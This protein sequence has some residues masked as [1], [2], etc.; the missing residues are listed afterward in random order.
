MK[1]KKLESKAI[2]DFLKKNPKVNLEAFN[3]MSLVDLEAL[4]WP[5]GQSAMKMLESLKIFQRLMRLTDDLSTAQ[6]LYDAGFH[7]AAQIASKPKQ[8]FISQYS[9]CFVANDETA[10]AQAALVYQRAANIFR[11]SQLIALNVMPKPYYQST[12]F[13]SAPQDDGDPSNFYKTMPSYQDLFGSLDYCA[14]EDCQSVLSPAAYFVDLMRLINEGGITQPEDDKLKLSNRRSDLWEIPLDC[15]NTNQE[16]PYLDLVNKILIQAATKSMYGAPEITDPDGINN[17]P[18]FILANAVYP[19]N[20]PS[21]LPLD[22]L[23]C[24]LKQNNVSLVEIYRLFKVGDSQLSR[25]MLSLSIEKLELITTED[26]NED[27]LQTYYNV[28][29]LTTLKAV[30]TFMQQTGLT[31][32]QLENLIYQNLSEAELDTIEIPNRLFINQ[33]LTNKFMQIASDPNNGTETLR[34]INHDANYDYLH[35]FIRLAGQLGWQFADLDWALRTTSA[36]IPNSKSVVINP[37]A[38]HYLARLNDFHRRYKTPIDVLCSFFA[39]IKTTG[40]GND[41]VSQALFDRV[42]NQPIVFDDFSDEGNSTP[43]YDT[44]SLKKPYHPNYDAE[45]DDVLANPLYGDVPLTWTYSTGTGDDKQYRAHLLSA[46]QISDADLDFILQHMS[47]NRLITSDNNIL[48]DVPHLTQLYRF[49]QAAQL[50]KMPVVENVLLHDMLNIAMIQSIDD[51]CALEEWVDWLKT[52]P[53][54]TYQLHYLINYPFAQAVSLRPDSFTVS[55]RA[56]NIGL[57]DSKNIFNQLLKSKFITLTGVVINKQ[58]LTLSNMQTLFGAGTS[59][60][61]SDDQCSWIQSVLLRYYQ[62]QYNPLNAANVSIKQLDV[63]YDNDTVLPLVNQLQESASEV[64]IN[65]DN[66]VCND[67]ESDTEISSFQSKEIFALLVKAELIT[68]EGVV[69]HQDDTVFAHLKLVV[70]EMGLKPIVENE[71]ALAWQIIKGNYK[72]AWPVIKKE[73][74]E[75][76]AAIKSEYKK[77]QTAIEDTVEECVAIKN[78]YEADRVFIKSVLDKYLV[79]QTNAVQEKLSNFLDSPVD[80]VNSLRKILPYSIPSALEF[81][82][83]ADCYVGIEGSDLF[84]LSEKNFTIDLWVNVSQFSKTN[85]EIVSQGLNWWLCQN[86]DHNN[87]LHFYLNTTAGTQYATVNYPDDQQW[88]HIAVTF[89]GTQLTLFVDGLKGAPTKI[90]ENL[91][92]GKGKIFLGANQHNFDKNV[93]TTFKGQMARVRIWSTVKAIP[94][95]MYDDTCQADD[96]QACWLL[97]AGYGHIIYNAAGVDYPGIIS[98]GT[99][100][101]HNYYFNHLLEYTEKDDGKSIIMDA[102]L[103][104]AQLAKHNNLAQWLNLDAEVMQALLDCPQSFGLP[105]MS[106]GF[107]YSPAL[108]RSLD[109][110]RVFS[111]TFKD[112]T[113]K[114]LTYFAISSQDEAVEQSNKI[115]SLGFITGWDEADI[116]L[117][118]DALSDDAL[119]AGKGYDFNSMGGIAV[120]QQ[121]FQL[122]KR[123]NNQPQQLID[124]ASLNDKYATEANW[125]FY[126][127]IVTDVLQTSTALATDPNKTETDFIRQESDQENERNLLAGYLLAQL[128][129]IFDDIKT[130][131]DL[132]AFLLV[133][134]K[135][136]G[137]TMISPIKLGINSL[138]LYIQRCQLSLENEATY[139]IPDRQWQWMQ[140]YVIWRANRE[141]YLYPENYID[142][143]LRRIKT[144]PYETLQSA[145]LQGDVTEKTV[146]DAL[147]RYVDE[148]ASI[149]NMKVVDA[150]YC[151]LEKEAVFCN[152]A[153]NSSVALGG[154]TIFLFAKSSLEASTF[155]HRTISL[156]EIK[157]DKKNLKPAHYASPWRK[158]D[159][160]ISSDTLSGIYAFNT[161]YVFWVEQ[162][163]K[164]LTDDSDNQYAITTAAIKFSFQTTDGKWSPPQ[165][166]QKDIVIFASG[167]KDK[168]YK[169]YHDNLKGF[170]YTPNGDYKYQNEWRKVQLMLTQSDNQQNIL[171]EYGSLVYSDGTEEPTLQVSPSD[172]EEVQQFNETMYLAAKNAYDLASSE[173]QTSIIPALMLSQDLAV[174]SYFLNYAPGNLN[175]DKIDYTLIQPGDTP[176]KPGEY[177]ES[178][179]EYLYYNAP[180]QLTGYWSFDDTLYDVNDEY[181]ATPNNNSYSWAKDTQDPLGY[182]YVLSCEG[183]YGWL[184]DTSDSFSL[185]GS[186]NTYMLIDF[187]FNEQSFSDS[188]YLMSKENEWDLMIGKDNSGS[189][190]R[191]LSFKFYYTGTFSTDSDDYIKVHTNNQTITFKDQEWH[192]VSIQVFCTPKGAAQAQVRVLLD[193]DGVSY[194]SKLKNVGQLSA[195]TSQKQNIEFCKSATA[196][197]NVPLYYGYLSGLSIFLCNNQSDKFTIFP[198]YYKG[199]VYNELCQSFPNSGSH[200]VT[201]NNRPNCICYGTGDDTF[202]ITPTIDL[203]GDLSKSRTVSLEGKYLVVAFDIKPKRSKIISIEGE[204]IY[205]KFTRLSTSVVNELQRKLKVGGAK[206]LLTLSSQDAEELP[207]DRYN[208]TSV[209]MT[210]RIDETLNF[211]GAYGCYFWELFF[212]IPFLIANQFNAN[213]K[214][215]LSKQWYEHV[216][217]PSDGD[218]CWRFIPLQN[219]PSDDYDLDNMLDRPALLMI[220]DNDPFDPD[221]LARLQHGSYQKAIVM[222]YIDNL[223]QWGDALFSQYTW[224]TNTEATLLY[225]LADDLLG[226]EP[227][228]VYESSPIEPQTFTQLE[229]DNPNGIPQFLI[230]VEAPLTPPAM[231][232]VAMDE[233]QPFNLFQSYFCISENKRFMQYWKTTDDRLYKLRHGMNIQGQ[234]Q[235][236]ALFQEALDPKQLMSN[237]SSFRDQAGRL[238]GPAPSVPYYRFNVILSLARN[239]AGR[240]AQLGSEL[241]SALEKQSAEQMSL[242][243]VTQEAS[244]L[245]LM[246]QI[247]QDQINQLM[248]TQDSLE[249]SLAN[250]TLRQDTMKHLIEKGY[251]VWEAESLAFSSESLAFL[252]IAEALKTTATP[253]YLLPTEFGLVVGGS[254]PGGSL[255]CAA[256]VFQTAS[257]LCGHAAQI[258]ST[259]GQFQRRKHDWELQRDLATNDIAQMNAQIE[260]NDYAL[261]A[262]QQDLVINQR[263]IVYANKVERFVKTK[264][265]NQ[266]LY[267]WMAAR[268]STIYAQ[269]YQLALELATLAET[270]YQYELSNNA[271]FINPLG[272]DGHNQGLLAGDSLLFDLDRLETAYKCNNVRK[273][274]IEKTISLRQLNPEQWE[275]FRT[276]GQCSFSFDEKMFDYDYP[277]HYDRTITTISISIPAVVGPY[278]NIQASLTQ[279]AN[280]IVLEPDINA[281]DALING[282]EQLPMSIRSNWNANQQVAIT[283]GVNDDGL[284]VLNFGDERYL[285]F[286]GTG[287]VS[288]WKLSMPPASNPIDFNTI[289]D[290][291]IQ[292]KY[293]ATDGSHTVAKADAEQGGRVEKPTDF[294]RAVIALLPDYSGYCYVSLSQTYP[295]QWRAFI[296]QAAHNLTFLL[297]NSLFPYNVQ[298]PSANLTVGTH[299]PD[300]TGQVY[301]LPILAQDVASEC[302]SLTITLNDNSW[303]SKD[304]AAYIEQDEQRVAMSNIDSWTIHTEDIPQS[305]LNSGEQTINASKWLDIVMVVP[306]TGKLSW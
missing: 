217:K 108:V 54:T 176:Q 104:V 57:P 95:L 55:N 208:P 97:T 243:Q 214:F 258:S 72:K 113:N 110:Y 202:L 112:D 30:P 264:F 65:E 21:N 9:H 271:K 286:E 219:I 51:L 269:T 118:E 254:N 90:T 294:K 288:D 119:G 304:N 253:V 85:Q 15:D 123:L 68:P 285:P 145:L 53:L 43:Y 69:V 158:I 2:Q 84:T 122:A 114:L 132:Y 134:V 236:L 281:V 58:P 13:Y 28:S 52:S 179:D 300:S 273:L 106:F 161:L 174:K 187:Y 26:Q 25:E 88:H 101:W 27:D 124:L 284:F 157:A 213:Y 70:Y 170:R 297:S 168:K 56:Y 63:G 74:S 193:L 149:A 147:G 232:S 76:Q 121:C 32:Q 151:E 293:T 215:D 262:A 91:E 146:N 166:L 35:R 39:D 67:T 142:P 280:R 301:L 230:D 289:T 211:D 8:Q 107:T 180:I 154:A 235:P 93:D 265:T 103:L 102:Q 183:C 303:S 131:D 240:V 6:A 1:T 61:F 77:H 172:L 144:P 33:A 163:D 164:Q 205:F 194:D 228:M 153:Y 17:D 109:S 188:T 275:Q 40:Q 245:S 87:S 22:N 50:F 212:Y 250:A 78:S 231:L 291:I 80:R 252:A 225:V 178:S 47:V 81:T 287:A 222:R 49:S 37:L 127:Q 237:T 299:G 247:K 218:D 115:Q 3:F 165:T 10:E 42:F 137:S 162:Q 209:V 224:E 251:S 169:S 200:I 41:T 129:S 210:S 290:V 279:T 192:H 141:V 295:E 201:V 5:K 255:E 143:S 16:V 242:L 226:D 59:F 36:T 11:R 298:A 220:Y 73:Y 19:F 125:D 82:G 136:S 274:E 244:V 44:D 155:Y 173:C 135:M 246:T 167:G 195:P 20:L 99:G 305:L 185:V 177:F 14:C 126:N 229:S 128:S 18:Y 191:F 198:P 152:T 203:I 156:C 282:D 257:A 189:G 105:G 261:Q 233:S 296:Q 184:S 249:S 159:V 46:L 181:Q 270:A 148:L 100:K 248:A 196:S 140:N 75:H 133:D 160:T 227:Q 306:F 256:G 216:F 182:T 186:G 277:G 238:S 60:N 276:T 120:L 259:I 283:R 31:R 207:F 48:L 234:A 241:L 239:M 268:L 62:L 138:Q 190:L 24:Y 89:D 23:R 130:V 83:E 221:T 38:I 79:L 263:S 98:A 96:L 7:S 111:T 34:H 302:S 175:E 45:P 206:H 292:L 86:N 171:V 66:F 150:Y 278:Q 12:L 266:E 4:T 197:P 260:A 64:L 117:L 204:Q 116:Y 272:W 139:N 94:S 199:D 29:D 92:Q 223:I 267:Q 71:P